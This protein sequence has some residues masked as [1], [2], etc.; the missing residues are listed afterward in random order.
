MN[1][2]ALS[3]T[4]KIEYLEDCIRAIRRGAPNVI[5]CPYC[6]VKNSEHKVYIC[7]DLF[8]EATN[9][10]LD[11]ME[12]QQAIDFFANVSDKAMVN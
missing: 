2:A 1:V 6:G 11:R 5:V 9:A 3:P 10:I 8:A 4:Q 7:C 12:K